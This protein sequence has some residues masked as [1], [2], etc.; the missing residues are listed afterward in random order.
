MEGVVLLVDAMKGIQAQTI[1]NYEQALA[2]QLQIIPVINKIDM[3]MADPD[4]VE[5]SMMGLFGFKADEVLRI[6]AKSNLH[7]E[8]LTNA[9]IQRLNPPNIIGIDYA[10]ILIFD[11]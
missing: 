11:S 10:K 5:K 1:S 6:S 7:I 8:T 4:T 9:I 2:C 3:H